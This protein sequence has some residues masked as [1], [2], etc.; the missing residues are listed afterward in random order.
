MIP[1]YAISLVS[2]VLITFS[3][4]WVMQVLI[5]TGKRAIVDEADFQLGDFIR[6]KKEE[7][8]RR[9][10]DEPEKPPEVEEP[11]PDTPPQ[12]MDDLDTS[13]SLSIGGPRGNLSLSMMAGGRVGLG[14]GDF[15]P[16][17]KVAPI[18]PRRAQ[19]RGLEGQCLI[20][21]TVDTTGATKDAFAVEC[22][23]SL[24]EKASINAV[25]KFKYKPRVVDGVAKEVPG[26][27]HIITFKLED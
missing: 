18:Y 25:L 7:V 20:E 19:T 5:A 21:F 16:I 17:V 4:L 9:D 22:T 1:R 23:S 14:D 24:F 26:V 11:P 15:L 3:L 13:Q 6:V 8:V 27:Q 10:E 12:Q 2:G